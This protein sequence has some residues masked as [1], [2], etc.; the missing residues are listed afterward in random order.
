MVIVG[1]T[2]DGDADTSAFR[3]DT[4]A[5]IPFAL[6]GVLLFATSAAY[7]T[8]L[9]GQGLVNEDRSV[10]RAVER[11][12]ADT[13]AALKAAA[14]E[15]AHATAAQPVTRAPNETDAPQTAPVRSESAFEDAFRIRLALAAETSLDAVAT[16]VADVSAAATFLNP[17]SD[18][19]VDDLESARNRVTIDAVA[20]GTATR[21]T[22][23]DVT[24]TAVRGNRR[25]AEMTRDR[26]VVV[27]VPTLGAHER[28]ERF[29]AQ[30][31]RGPVEGPGLGRQLTASLY[32]MTWARGYAQY[33][34]APV[35]NVLANRHVELSTN[36]GIVRTQRDVFGTSDPAARGGV[37]EATARTGI[38]DLLAPTT[39][40]ESAW[41]DLVLDT[42][43]P[44][45]DGP[46][47]GDGFDAAATHTDET[48]SVPVGHA[49]D[50]A[51]VGVH[52]DLEGALGRSY[53][54]EALLDASATQVVNGGVPRPPRP[55]ATPS[56][57]EWIHVD[58][59]HGET[60]RV[61][62]RDTVP[63]GVPTGTVIP[64]EPVSFGSA[65]REVIVDRTVTR[66]WNRVVERD[67]GSED[68]RGADADAGRTS[69]DGVD[70]TAPVA[71]GGGATRVGI[72]AGVT[73]D[74]LSPTNAR[75]TGADDRRSGTNVV[76]RTT[77]S[78]TVTDRYRVAISV[79]G[80]YAPNDDAPDRSV[81]TFGAGG[82]GGPDLVGT[83]ATARSVLAV[84]TPTAVDSVARAAVDGDVHRSTVVFGEPS[85]NAVNRIG[86]DLGSLRTVVRDI[87]A[88][89]SMEDVAAGESN[90]YERLVAAVRAREDELVGAP[91]TYD[92]AEDRARVAVRVRYID[93]VVD[94]L[95]SAAA[96]DEAATSGFLDRVEGIFDGP[97]LGEILAS[98]E[99]ARNTGTYRV[100][101]T[102]P[103]GN[104]TFVPTGSPGYLPRTAID[105]ASVE[106]VD[107]TTT[108]P[109]A[110]RNVNYVTVPYGDIA[111]GIVDRVLG[112]EDTVRIGVAGRAL[113]AAD[114][115]L[116]DT[117]HGDSDSELR[118]DRDALTRRTEASMSVADTR[119][120]SALGDR[121]SLSLAE[122][123]SV[124][125]AVAR[126]YDSPGERAVAID[127]GE[128]AERVTNE[129]ARR[130][131][132]SDGERAA[133]AVRLG[134]TL[135]TATGRD[136]VRVPTRFV[137]GPT[138]RV[139]E[140]ARGEIEDVVEDGI[141]HAGDEA[142]ARWA[143]TPVRR[144]GAGLPVAPVPGY[145]VATV[146]AW[147]VEVRGT[148]PRFTIRSDV[149][150]PEQ[151][152]EYVREDAVVT[153]T[154]DGDEIV[155]GS[156][157]PIAFETGTIVAVAV[158]PGPPGVGDV[159][160][161][162][163]ETSAGW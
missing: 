134:V 85:A 145:W 90:P 162:R 57:G 144:V 163:D 107:G 10:E 121:T 118:A 38:R 83:P 135:R 93:A 81:T 122:R 88:E 136:A 139:R 67:A 119:L 64:G 41:S 20:N 54:V 40:D 53:R 148:Y 79:D 106:A 103:G 155:L 24:V 58:T 27:A 96:D 152:F 50:V 70:R 62:E 87:E 78:A 71:N 95:E 161:T 115:V 137:D 142:A 35:R 55:D 42:P 74:P 110:T 31:N 6:I 48:T 21:V 47:D 33:A 124:L 51:A 138:E 14:R 46:R 65:S 113:L 2:R 112:T 59:S 52:D 156:T 100:G 56:E 12:D 102:G 92:G 8:G 18:I 15:A 23:E 125:D 80:L 28:T 25:V 36:A 86:T 123:R 151:P 116:D 109:L 158:P 120:V 146:N 108:R 75:R 131:S 133:L 4:R 16:D 82:D 61:V 143:P 84:D 130:A 91:V 127:D 34:G 60:T 101:T 128:Y 99:A 153:M 7:A 43:T 105:G 69:D 63:D 26:T 37:A 147:R 94:E 72:V 39:L 9:A 141:Q 149:G 76:E 44:T 11:V 66:T 13:T 89:L 22:F 140:A 114:D 111:G 159:D 129:V 157:E 126:T 150:T 117:D 97:S 154:V 104:V 17:D 1:R 5:R 19:D 29:E 32:P 77:T 49:A 45:D 30:L 132:L 160:G 3:H 73:R 98:R 68:G